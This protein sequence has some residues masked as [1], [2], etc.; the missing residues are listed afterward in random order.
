VELGLGAF[1]FAS[2]VSPASGNRRQVDA[3]AKGRPRRARRARGSSAS[4]GPGHPS[5]RDRALVRFVLTRPVRRFSEIGYQPAPDPE[6]P[7]VLVLAQVGAGPVWTHTMETVVCWFAVWIRE[8]HRDHGTSKEKKKREQ[9]RRTAATAG[10]QE[11]DA[12]RRPRLRPRGGGCACGRGSVGTGDCCIH[13]YWILGYGC[14][15]T[16]ASPHGDLC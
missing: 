8:N 13:G 11:E 1:G 6:G 14:G 7:V 9:L 12:A 4:L 3:R 5:M 10:G 2:L 15:L 16:T